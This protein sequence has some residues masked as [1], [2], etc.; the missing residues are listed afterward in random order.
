MKVAELDSRLVRMVALE[1]LKVNP[2]GVKTAEVANEAR[3]AEAHRDLI[4]INATTYQTLVGKVLGSFSR[5]AA[6]DSTVA[7]RDMLWRRA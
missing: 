7:A 6:D 1:L 5:L 4:E 2:S 3:V